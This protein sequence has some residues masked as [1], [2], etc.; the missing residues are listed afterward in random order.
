MEFHALAALGLA[1]AVNASLP[2]P[3]VVAI[4]GSTMREGWGGAARL[5]CGLILG[6]VVLI[7]VALGSVAGLVAVSPLSLVAMK[8]GGIA[9]LIGFAALAVRPRER[10]S[11]RET[12]PRGGIL[13]AGFALGVSSPFNLVFYLAVVPPALSAM[14]AGNGSTLGPLSCAAICVAALGGVVTGMAGIVVFVSWLRR[15][16]LGGRWADYGTAAF[17]LVTAATAAFAPLQGPGMPAVAE[18]SPG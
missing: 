9:T 3:C 14:I 13:A 2:G 12:G 4:A 7:T 8:W 11:G 6:D 17:L 10:K 1:A 15:G 18:A 5:C 16:P